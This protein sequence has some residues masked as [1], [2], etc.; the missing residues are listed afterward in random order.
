MHLEIV[1]LELLFGHLRCVHR[2]LHVLLYVPDLKYIS[3]QTLTHNEFSL[4][5]LVVNVLMEN[6]ASFLLN[7]TLYGLLLLVN[8]LLLLLMRLLLVML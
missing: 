1:K 5:S 4:L 8:L 3:F 7:L 2:Y 6:S